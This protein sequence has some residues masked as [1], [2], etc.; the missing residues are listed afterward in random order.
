MYYEKVELPTKDCF[1]SKDSEV[2]FITIQDEQICSNCG[3]NI[4]IE[5]LKENLK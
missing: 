1:C 2:H 5:Y 4:P 3:A